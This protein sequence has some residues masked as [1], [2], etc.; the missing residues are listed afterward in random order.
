MFPSEI[1]MPTVQL[2][3]KYGNIWENY[4]LYQKDEFNHSSRILYIFVRIRQFM[5]A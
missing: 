4:M 2:L 1:T 5:H 3:R